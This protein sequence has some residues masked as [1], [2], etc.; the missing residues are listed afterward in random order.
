MHPRLVDALKAQEEDERLTEETM[1]P[2]GTFRAEDE[3]AKAAWLAHE[4]ATQLRREALKA[5]EE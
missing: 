1:T 2:R 4:R 3:A 5:I